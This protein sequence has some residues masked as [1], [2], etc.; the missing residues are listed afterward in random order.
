MPV[1]VQLPRLPVSTLPMMGLPET[2][3]GVVLAGPAAEAASTDPAHRTARA[4]T[5]TPHPIQRQLVAESRLGMKSPSGP[6]EPLRITT[7]P[8]AARTVRL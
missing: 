1:P 7:P 4:V 3:G 5:A 8:A 2:D 6:V